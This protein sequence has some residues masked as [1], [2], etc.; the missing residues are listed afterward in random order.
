MQLFKF[1]ALFS[2]PLIISFNVQAGDE[3]LLK[4]CQ[5]MSKNANQK[6][7]VY[8]NY[9]VQGYVTGMLLNDDA[10]AKELAEAGSQWSAFMERAYRTRV[11]DRKIAPSVD[12]FRHFCPS[13]DETEAQI[14]AN[15]SKYLVDHSKDIQDL[16]DTLYLAMQT[17]YPCN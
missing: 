1:L 11:G 2:L 13:T 14:I 6:S 15:I 7:A 16:R 3:A 17:E 5:A 8:C 10:N 12:G 9:Y 4:S